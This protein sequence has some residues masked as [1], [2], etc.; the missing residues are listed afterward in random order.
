MDAMLTPRKP[1]H[2]LDVTV[3]MGG[4][5]TEREISLISGRAVADALV[6]AGHRVTRAD[7]SPESTGALDRQGIDVV[8]IALHGDFGESGD[9]QQ[10]CEDRHL[11][12][13][14]AGVAASRTAIDKAASKLAARDAGRPVF[15]QGS[16]LVPQRG[17][18][19]FDALGRLAP[20]SEYDQKKR[21][22]GHDHEKMSSLHEFT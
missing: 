22:R 19:F 1:P 6:R 12:Y 16:D 10:L 7:I 13:V 20:G 17:D 14:G 2:P 9:V 21:N 11:P 8:F 15:F 4:P 3:L 5:S 18:L